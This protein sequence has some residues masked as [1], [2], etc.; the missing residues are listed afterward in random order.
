[1]TERVKGMVG[2]FVAGSLMFSSTAAAAS[3]TGSPQLN[4]WGVL[5]AMSGGAPAAAMCGAAVAAAAAQNPTGCVLP[6]IDS[7]PPVA[8]AAPA[9]PAPVPPI[10]APSGAFAINPIL[11]GLLALAAGVGIYFAV[12][13]H[14]NSPT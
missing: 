9:P 2:L 8:Q 6:A 4:P 10:A 7:P 1:M 11:L 3:A 14:G 12:R 13:H 5:S